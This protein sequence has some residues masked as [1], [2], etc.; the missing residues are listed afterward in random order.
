MRIYQLDGRGA[1][2]DADGAGVVAIGNFDGVHLGH[3]QV[4]ARVLEKSEEIGSP[5][6]VMTFE[7]YPR[8]FFDPHHAPPRLTSCRQKFELLERAGIDR[9]YC[10]RFGS[11]LAATTA[12]DFVAVMLVE[13]LK[14]SHVVVGV[15]FRFGAA[16]A[17][18]VGLLVRLG[19][20]FGFGVSAIDDFEREGERVSSSRIRH[21]LEI[22]DLDGAASLLGRPFSYKSR[23]IHGDRRG[24]TIGF[25]TANL[26]V[27]RNSFPLSG[28]FVVSVADERGWHAQGVANVG[29]RPTVDGSRLLLE[30][31]LFDYSGSLYG[32][33]LEVTFLRQVRR[34]RR[35][36]SFEAL[37]TQITRDCEYAR[38][39]LA[40]SFV[41]E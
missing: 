20:E 36:E 37:K 6:A 27:R 30:V 38:G 9:V 13:R 3:R 24:R 22:G 40:E 34:E 7:P 19:R 15:D 26:G 8:E 31:H 25:P 35:F 32:R 23:V 16:R 4:I 2:S 10:A 5:A 17:G 21:L 33:R 14:V 18:D 41:H 11:K 28:V 12:H 1:G 29:R 39:W